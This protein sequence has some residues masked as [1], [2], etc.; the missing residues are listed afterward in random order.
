V[1][2]LKVDAATMEKLLANAVKARYAGA[3][4][5]LVPQLHDLLAMKMFALATGGPKRK[6]KDFGDIVNLV[7]ENNVD[8]DT[9]LQELSQQFGNDAIYAELRARI[10]ELRHA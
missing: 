10:Q 5:V 7:I 1:D 3:A 2:F 4:D 9:D 6:H 8:V